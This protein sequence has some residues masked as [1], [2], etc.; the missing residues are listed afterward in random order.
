MKKHHKMLHIE[1]T[2]ANEEKSE[3]NYKKI[4]K[5]MKKQEEYSS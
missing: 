2:N 4:E 5:V 3:V 1:K